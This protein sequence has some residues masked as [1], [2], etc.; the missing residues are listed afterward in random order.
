MKIYCVCKFCSKTADDE[1]SIEINFS[2]GKMF[3]ICPHC[4]K[5]NTI[6]LEDKKEPLPRTRLYRG[7]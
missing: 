1:V 2:S 3:Y 7:R 6:V 5:E 4:K